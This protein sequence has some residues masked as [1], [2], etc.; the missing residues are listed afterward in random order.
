MLVYHSLHPS[1]SPIHLPC[2]GI[3]FVQKNQAQTLEYE[4]YKSFLM[5]F[6]CRKKYSEECISTSSFNFAWQLR[7]STFGV[8]LRLTTSSFD[9][10]VQTSPDDFVVQLSTVN[11]AWQLRRS[12]SSFK[13]RR[14][15][16]SFN[17]VC[18]LRRQEFNFARR[19]R[20][21]EVNFAGRR[22]RREARNNL[23]N[24]FTGRE[25]VWI[26]RKWLLRPYV[27]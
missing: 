26:W 17:F 1:I 27:K 25:E 10:I 9:F 14:S 22:S 5:K 13:L 24:K 21:H 4:E 8:Q 2:W 18:R 7:R 6:T 23:K 20:Q 19:L 12:T 15:T 3:D 11:F 16:S